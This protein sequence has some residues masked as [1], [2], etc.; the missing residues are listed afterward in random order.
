MFQSLDNF[1]I[2]EIEVHVFVDLPLEVFV[3][4]D[5]FVDILKY[6][7][8]ELKVTGENN[9]EPNFQSIY[10]KYGKISELQ[11]NC[12]WHFI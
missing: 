12:I 6:L 1:E 7:S 5:V 3:E 4:I 10:V 9:H 2:D 11:V 8:I